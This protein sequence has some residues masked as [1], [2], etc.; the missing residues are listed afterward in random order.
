MGGGSPSPCRAACR[1]RTGF[2]ILPLGHPAVC[3][4]QDPNPRGTRT[5]ARN[6][7]ATGRVARRA[8]LAHVPEHRRSTGLPPVRPRSRARGR[9]LPRGLSPEASWPA[10]GRPR[11]LRGSNRGPNHQP[12]RVCNGRNGVRSWIHTPRA[13]N[14]RGTHHPEPIACKASRPGVGLP[15]PRVHDTPGPSVRLRACEEAA[16]PPFSEEYRF[17]WVAPRPPQPAPRAGGR[18]RRPFLSS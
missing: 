14:P 11:R 9:P 5:R 6:G 13:W 1:T 17:A 4:R 18:G 10:V 12:S 8:R 2:P 3:C 15:V 16:S 7:P